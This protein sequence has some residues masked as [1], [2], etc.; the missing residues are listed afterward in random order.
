MDHFSYRDGTL[1]A[2]DVSLEDVADAVGTPAFVYSAATVRRHYH[3]YAEAFS[4]LD[5]LICYAV[6]ANGNIAVVNT[7][8]RE[9]A[10]ADVVSAGELT[11]ALRAG[12]PADRIVFSGVAKG[13]DEMAAAL[14]AGILQI[15][16]ESWPEL[17]RL[18]AVAQD[19]G[20]RAPVSI[21][22]NPDVDAKTHAKITTGRAENKFGIDHDRAAEIYA[23]ARDMA[24]IEVTG[25]A[26]H[27]GSQLTDLAP[28][29]A[30]YTRVRGLVEA[31]RA[32]GHDIRRIDLGG[33]LGIPYGDDA[34]RDA[35][36]PSPADY[37]RMAAEILDG[38][39]CRVLLEPG[40]LIVGNAGVL[41]SRVAYVKDGASRTFV[42]LDT[43]MNDLIRPSL[44]DAFHAVV[45]VRKPA[46]DAPSRAVDIV[47]PICE[48]GD[49]FAKARAM[50][51]VEAGDLL[52]F[53]SAGAYAAVMASMYNAR[54]LAPEVLVD[55]ARFTVV[56]ERVSVEQ[57]LD[58]ERLADDPVADPVRDVASG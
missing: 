12:V 18:N 57:Q 44:Y 13:A 45:P 50:A 5:A 41:L 40:R 39:G 14:D 56:R 33:G 31:L 54:P 20:R 4:G 47:G 48:T 55:G 16:V 49:T 7:L 21:R 24:G 3:V 23:A 58:W 26:V 6:K 53:R 15:N 19:R 37:G 8:A 22:V 51:P 29:R 28:Y 9:G 1:W 43:G 17:E 10:G 42:I 30:A 2:E 36:I 46:D 34:E 35:G 25:I 38:L 52:A 32:D 27:I 11:R